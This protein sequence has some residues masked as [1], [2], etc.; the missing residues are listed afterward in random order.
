MEAA[1]GDKIIVEAE[2]AD[3]HGRTG[4]IEEVLSNEPQRLQVRWDD[5]HTSIF[6]PTAGVARIERQEQSATA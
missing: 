4:V 1:V 6:C 2:R 5:G 3:Q